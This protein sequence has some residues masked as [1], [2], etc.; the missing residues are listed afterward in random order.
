MT[1]NP[2][3]IGND[4]IKFIFSSTCKAMTLIGVQGTATANKALF[5]SATNARY[6]VPVGKKFVVLKCQV[7]AAQATA[8]GTDPVCELKYNT[9]TTGGTKILE[10]YANINNYATSVD[11]YCEVAA[12]NY[13]NGDNT[14]AN[15]ANITVLGVECDS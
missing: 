15:F 1:D 11:C 6:V 12:G 4:S 5:D 8:V 14:T 10:V 2:V 9:T 13:I 7:Q 3:V